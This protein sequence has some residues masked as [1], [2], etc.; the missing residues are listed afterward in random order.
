MAIF[1]LKFAHT[2]L[3]TLI[4]SYYIRSVVYVGKTTLKL[5]NSIGNA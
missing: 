2:I 3:V 4:S 5:T 1:L